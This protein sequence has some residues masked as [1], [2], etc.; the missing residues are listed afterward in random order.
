[1]LFYL[2]L[3]SSLNLLLYTMRGKDWDFCSV[4]QVPFGS[5]NYLS[6]IVLKVL[7]RLID[8]IYVWV[9][10]WILH[11]VPLFYFLVLCEYHPV[12]GVLEL[13]QVGSWEQTAKFV[14]LK[15]A[16]QPW[17]SC[18]THSKTP[19]PV[20]I[21]VVICNGVSL[22]T[23]YCQVFQLFFKTVLTILDPLVF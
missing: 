14:Y 9:Y 19:L 3:R 21:I 4:V 6:Q 13:T 23:R 20:M 16:L 12:N 2:G 17:A 18:Q 11:S 1:M 7:R 15:S 22:E 5:K 8:Y 10:F